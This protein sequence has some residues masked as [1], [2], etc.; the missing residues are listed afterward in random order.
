MYNDKIYLWFDTLH[1]LHIC[2]RVMALDLRHAECCFGS[3]SCPNFIY[4]FI[5]TRSS[6]RL[7][8]I[9]F[10]KFVLELWP[11]IYAKILFQLNNLDYH[12]ILY[13]FILT[14]SSL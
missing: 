3:V 8:H 6:F 7:L 12:Q 4:A 13:A 14:I 5:L 11:L 1:F 2:A 9:I 10:R